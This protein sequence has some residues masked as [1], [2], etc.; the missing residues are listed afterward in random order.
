MFTES[1]SYPIINKLPVIRIQTDAFIFRTLALIVGLLGHVRIRLCCRPAA[2][3][4]GMVAQ[5]GFR[6]K[7]LPESFDV[8]TG[9]N[10]KWSAR[11]GTQSYGTPIV[12]GGRVYIGTNNEIPRDPNHSADSGVLMC[13]D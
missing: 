5:Y 4:P 11:L 2:V 13:F 9:R 3:G 7:G 10:V 6:G 8:K 1:P 12:A